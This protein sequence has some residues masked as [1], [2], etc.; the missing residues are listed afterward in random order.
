MYK[1]FEYQK[2]E[3]LQKICNCQQ[4]HLQ[5]GHLLSRIHSLESNLHVSQVKLNEQQKKIDNTEDLERKID[6]MKRKLESYEVI[7]SEL[8]DIRKQL[9]SSSAVVPPKPP[10]PPPPPPLPVFSISAKNTCNTFLKMVHSEKKLISYENPRP[11]ITLEDI[12]NV[13]LK[14]TSVSMDKTRVR[15]RNLQFQ[16]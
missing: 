3:S 16:I 12:L 7:K 10:V 1:N 11:M 9:S 2:C 8:A 15:K 13:K 14:K 5:M 4:F 6:E